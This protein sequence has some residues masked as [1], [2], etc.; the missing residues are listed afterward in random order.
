MHRTR[1]KSASSNLKTYCSDII[2]VPGGRLVLCLL[3]LPSYASSLALPCCCGWCCHIFTSLPHY[4]SFHL[5]HTTQDTVL[6]QLTQHATLSTVSTSSSSC[7][8]GKPG[9]GCQEMQQSF[10]VLQ[11]G[12]AWPDC[13]F[14]P[15]TQRS[16][17]GPPALHSPWSQNCRNRTC[18]AACYRRHRKSPN[19]PPLKRDSPSTSTRNLLIR[20]NRKKTRRVPQ[21]PAAPTAKGPIAFIRSLHQH[22]PQHTRSPAGTP[23]SRLHS[24]HMV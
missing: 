23:P 4:V 10:H 8:G 14:T 19:Q 24:R 21:Q 12:T 17:H 15:P 1:G 20:T 18:L 9:T 11:H 3:R 13:S 5:A 6:Q 22:Q 7:L 2:G 16:I